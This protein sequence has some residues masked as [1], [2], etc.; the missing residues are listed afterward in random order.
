MRLA[1]ITLPGKGCLVLGSRM[2]PHW[3]ARGL[4]TQNEELVGKTPLP[5]EL[6]ARF[7][8]NCAFEGKRPRKV[9]DLRSRNISP[10]LKKKSLLRMIGPPR[11]APKSLKCSGGFVT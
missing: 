8:S 4:A 7:P 1:G 2:S 9:D 6:S 5:A 11:D 10:L 3:D